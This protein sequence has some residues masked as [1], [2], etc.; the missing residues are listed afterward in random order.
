MS[1]TRLARG[2]PF[3]GEAALMGSPYS[4]VISRC[5]GTEV[6]PDLG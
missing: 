4:S 5:V 6:A 2:F 3:G 1:E